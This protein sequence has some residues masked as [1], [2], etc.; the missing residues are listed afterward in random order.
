MFDTILSL[1][2]HKFFP[3]FVYHIDLS[4][5]SSLFPT[6]HCHYT[7]SFYELLRSPRVRSHPLC[8]S[9][10]FLFPSILRAHLTHKPFPPIPFLSL[11]HLLFQPCRPTPVELHLTLLSLRAEGNAEITSPALNIQLLSLLEPRYLLECGRMG[12]I[13]YSR[14]LIQPSSS[15][16]E[17]LAPP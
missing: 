5:S 8:T 1:H 16:S 10:A 12:K 11:S 2:N 15:S 4:S 3:H 7:R 14:L 9:L 17:R 6:S 13:E